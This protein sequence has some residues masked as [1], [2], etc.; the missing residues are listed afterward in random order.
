MSGS[1]YFVKNP[2]IEALAIEL[3]NQDGVYGGSWLQVSESTRN[4]YREMAAGKK[5][6]AIVGPGKKKDDE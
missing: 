3:F 6:I 5:P 1:K 2:T 4:E